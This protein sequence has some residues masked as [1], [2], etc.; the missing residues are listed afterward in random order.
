MAGAWRMK[1]KMAEHSDEWLV[2]EYRAGCVQAAEELLER[3][4]R[5]VTQ[6][7]SRMHLIGGERDDLIQEGMIGLFKAIRGYDWSREKQS[8]FR[9]FAETCI[10]RNMY[11]AIEASLRQ[12]N[13]PLNSYVSLYEGGEGDEEA[14]PLIEALQ[15]K[16]SVDPETVLI[17]RENVEVLEKKIEEALSP[18]ER[19]VLNLTLVGLSYTQIA[20]ILG[21]TPKQIDNAL[22][23]IRRKLKQ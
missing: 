8:S 6:K 5:L 3:Y 4:K 20:E 19:E 12:K 10:A 18:M 7:A 15:D 17:D 23:R 1:E 16:G 11:T 22:Q 2:K 21:K 14:A 13:I 9:S